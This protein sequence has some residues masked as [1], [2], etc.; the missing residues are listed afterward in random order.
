MNQNNF[1]IIW[2]TVSSGVQDNC[3]LESVPCSF[4]WGAELNF[5][6]PEPLLKNQSPGTV[7]MDG[8]MHCASKSQ[9]YSELSENSVGIISYFKSSIYSGAVQY[10]RQII[11]VPSWD[12]PCCVQ[13]MQVSQ[14]WATSDTSSYDKFR[15]YLTSFICQ[16]WKGDLNAELWVQ[17][18]SRT[19]WVLNNYYSN[20]ICFKTLLLLNKESHI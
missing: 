9:E 2:Q 17:M 10:T 5:I 3:I 8:W 4:W 18:F 12:V 20:Q 14:Y 19:C 1:H 11:S 6:K 13:Q 7:R 15:Q 16:Y